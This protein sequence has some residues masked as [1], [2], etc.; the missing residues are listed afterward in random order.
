VEKVSEQTIIATAEELLREANG[1]LR[2]VSARKVAKRSGGGNQRVNEIVAAWR[3]R[4][5]GETSKL[6][7]VE[8]PEPL[9]PDAVSLAIEEATAKLRNLGPLVARL[10]EEATRIER[11]RCDREIA[12]EQE[13]MK[14]VV[15]EREKDLAAAMDES[16]GYSEDL[17]RLEMERAD[18]EAR[19]EDQHKDLSAER[20]EKARQ[21]EELNELQKELLEAERREE[22]A[23]AEATRQKELLGASE[24]TVTKLEA[25]LTAAIEAHR[26]EL[27]EGRRAHREELDAFRTDYKDLQGQVRE[28]A[29]ELSNAQATIRQLREQLTHGQSAKK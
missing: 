20:E 18:L 15:E 19:L 12:M 24:R 14:A 5:A 2:L 13:R 3:E 29:A 17:D 7:P 16:R 22:R 23:A 21:T 10:I 27:A 25:Q 1:E 8:G 6:D 26:H 11:Q 4:K 28:T 9:V